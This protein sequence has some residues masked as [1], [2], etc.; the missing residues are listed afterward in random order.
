MAISY[1]L[2]FPAP[3]FRAV[4]VRKMPVV[5]VSQS[6]YSGAQQAVVY[7]GQWWEMDLTLPTLS[8]A[9]CAEWEAFFGKLNGME[10]T[11]LAGDPARKVARGVCA[12]V[13]GTPLVDGVVAARSLSLPIKGGPIL[14]QGWI[15][16]GDYIQ[17]G[18]G[19]SAKLHQ[20][21]SSADTDSAGDTIVDVWPRV[22]AALAGDE[23]ISF[24][25]A[26]GVFRMTSNGIEIVK[27]VGV[28]GELSFSVR[29]AF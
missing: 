12:T 16:A 11:F 23:A 18:S 24:S 5:G 8:A 22:R 25:A 28:F 14:T 19:A 6:P 29:E 27:R 2:S 7:P 3:S 4:T 1:P 17:I 21:L 10:G 20:A 15:L 26:K 9:Q 13:P